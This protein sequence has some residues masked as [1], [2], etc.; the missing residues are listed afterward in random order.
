ME[1]NNK[2]RH[3]NML[4]HFPIYKWINATTIKVEMLGVL[5]Q[6]CNGKRQST[7][8]GT[9][10]GASFISPS[11]RICKAGGSELLWYPRPKLLQ[12]I[13]AA[14]KTFKNALGSHAIAVERLSFHYCRTTKQTHIR[15]FNFH[16]AS[17]LCDNKYC[18]KLTLPHSQQSFDLSAARSIKLKLKEKL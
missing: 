11:I 5:F 4:R 1:C 13:P 10:S 14:S 7:F 15:R 6:Y 9:N 12:D 17:C 8:N 3:L 16:F 18:R 2:I